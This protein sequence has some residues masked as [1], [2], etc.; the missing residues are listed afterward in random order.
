MW[1]STQ[2]PNAHY[3]RASEQ[4]TYRRQLAQLRLEAIEE[5]L[6]VLRVILPLGNQLELL[7]FPGLDTQLEVF[8]AM[9]GAGQ[10]LLD[11]LRPSEVHDGK[12]TLGTHSRRQS[13]L[14]EHETHEAVQVQLH[15][16]NYPEYL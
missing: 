7:L 3:R 6:E 12:D 9:L 8:E 14:R 11:A 16:N 1:S 2:A 4:V 15:L 5:L 13:H 10:G